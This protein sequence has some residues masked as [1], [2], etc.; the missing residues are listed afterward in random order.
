MRGSYKISNDSNIRYDCGIASLLSLS[1]FLVT[2]M[3]GILDTPVQRLSRVVSSVRSMQKPLPVPGMQLDAARR[4]F[5][6]GVVLLMV[7]VF[8]WTSSNFVTQVRE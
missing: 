8:L 4:Q 7:V 3:N 2:I 1:H 5:M 6:V